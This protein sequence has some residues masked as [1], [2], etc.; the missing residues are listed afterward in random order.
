MTV[1][2]NVSRAAALWP[3]RNEAVGGRA[4]DWCA[5]SFDL[6][7]TWLLICT[8]RERKRSAING[9]KPSGAISSALQSQ[10]PSISA[11]ERHQTHPKNAEQTRRGQPQ[12]QSRA[13]KHPRRA[14]EAQRHPTDARTGA[15]SRGCFPARRGYL[16]RRSPEPRKRHP[17]YA[18]NGRRDRQARKPDERGK[19]TAANGAERTRQ[20]ERH[21]TDEQAREGAPPDTKTGRKNETRDPRRAAAAER[22]ICRYEAN[23]P[24]AA[25]A[26]R[27][28]LLREPFLRLA[29]SPEGVLSF[30]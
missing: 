20:A 12:T 11:A 16:M 21:Q 19:A 30:S 1:A 9:E 18:Q 27:A 10:T 14:N 26:G 15:V 6:G 8:Q 13:A 3:I 24:Q 17:H 28:G 23:R 5:F 22:T 2:A 25:F 7:C 29:Y 4:P